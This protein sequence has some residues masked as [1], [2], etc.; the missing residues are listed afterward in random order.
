MSWIQ[1]HKTDKTFIDVNDE[2][3]K[4][5]KGELSDEMAKI[6]FGR[7]LMYN[8][9]IL[10]FWLTGFKLY[11]DQRLLIKGWLFKNFTLT[12]AGRGFS[13]SF[14]YTHFCYLYCL[15]NPGKRVI[16]IA[17]TFRS[18]RKIVENIG[19]WAS[20]KKGKLLRQ[21]IQPNRNGELIS[22]KPDLYEV[23]FKNGASII[24]LPLGDAEKLRGY[25]CSVL[26]IDEGLLVPQTIMDSVLKPFLVATPEE[27]IAR[28]QS[29]RE[30]EDYLI[31]KGKMREEDRAKF[32]SDVKM[33]V[34]SSAS[35][36]W[37]DLYTLYKKYLKI[38]YA[39]DDAM[40][41]KL[42]E[43]ELARLS[44][45]K[46]AKAEVLQGDDIP[47]SYLVHQLSYKV[48]P[49]DRIDPAVR[50]EI[51]SG[52]FSETD[53]KREYEAQFVQDSNG[54]FRA[55]IM[56]ECTLKGVNDP[57]IEI[58]GEKGAEYII[59]IDPNLGGS[60]ANDHF[61]ICVIKIIEKEF[62][63]KSKRKCGL[64][65][66]QYAN[67]GAKPEHHI[68]YFLYILTH[69][70]Y[71]YIAADT[72]QGSNMDFINFCNESSQFKQ[73]H[74]NLKPI[75]FADFGK[76]SF[77]DLVTDIQRGY[78]LEDGAIVQKQYFHSTFQKAANEY[79]QTCFNRRTLLFAAKGIPNDSAMSK[80]RNQDIG[81]ILSLHPD[82]CGVNEG[83]PGD[84]DDFIGQQDVLIDLVKKECALI[85]PK[86][87]SLGSVSFDL[88][89]HMKKNNKNPSRV[90]K[91][92]YSALF[93][94]NWALKLYLDT[95]ERPK[96][97]GGDF[98]ASW[99]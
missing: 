25:R 6:T 96:E 28:R 80:M 10:V 95:K 12:V 8:I 61:A 17:P 13:K 57:T 56:E 23:N 5:L 91:D 85:D 47:S 35:Y 11:P 86:M 76:E 2:L 7:F 22:K 46:D 40:V 92:N 33:I 59:A 51:E 45:D 64:V 41:K 3:E 68:G 71:V 65:V 26:G 21:C 39:Q 73:A 77:G 34:L 70:N 81:S 31:S 1:G 32:S 24:A 27:E 42:D 87:S 18:S 4:T 54:Y 94:G 82:F 93:L 67:A 99:A 52:M 15:F 62:S 89:S 53:V 44:D 9:G 19:K 69:F 60:E 37:Q 90:R 29:I 16:M 48:A 75:Q 88:P 72:T 66:H 83:E 55:S 50:E 58:V 63:D 20:S 98:Y 84:M 97:D 43:K 78:C 36:A 38:I 49:W 79:M 74:I 14:L 30:R